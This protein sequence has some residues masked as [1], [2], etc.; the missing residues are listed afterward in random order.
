MLLSQ[1]PIIHL[2]I[3]ALLILLLIIMVQILLVY[4]A[5]P[6]S[7]SEPALNVCKKATQMRGWGMPFQLK[8]KQRFKGPTWRGGTSW[9]EQVMSSPVRVKAKR[10]KLR[11]WSDLSSSASSEGEGACSDLHDFK[12]SANL[13]AVE[14][15]TPSSLRE[16]T[17]SSPYLAAWMHTLYMMCWGMTEAGAIESSCAD[18][19]LQDFTPSSKSF[20]PFCLSSFP[21]IRDISRCHSMMGSISGPDW[22]R[23]GMGT[24]VFFLWW[25]TTTFISPS[26]RKHLTVAQSQLKKKLSMGTRLGFMTYYVDNRDWVEARKIK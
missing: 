16:S 2:L 9:K 21:D 15:L 4:L 11:Q 5:K 7:I 25:C 6:G 24:D 20:M 19:L 1:L 17:L 12:T 13:S 26:G 22:T 10:M 3:A 8:T 23:T 14:I 18:S